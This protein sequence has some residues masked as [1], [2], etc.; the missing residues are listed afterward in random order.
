M[1]VPTIVELINHEREFKVLC[2]GL[3]RFELGPFIQTYAGSGA[4]GG[5]DAD[6]IGTIDGRHGRWVFQ[7][8]FRS[9]QAGV[10]AQRAW[11]LR[12]YEAAKGEFDKAGVQGAVGYVLMTNVP[13]TAGSVAKLRQAWAARFGDA[14]FV[15]WDPSQLDP[16]L[17]G[18]EHL[19]RSWT[20]E[21]EA[22]CRE[23]LAAPLWAWLLEA[24]QR[25]A[26]WHN[27]PLWPLDV[28]HTQEQV[29]DGTFRVGF[30]FRHGYAVEPSTR[31]LDDVARDPQFP[32]ASGTAYPRAL[33]PLRKLR[34]AIDVLNRAVQR[35][36]E[37]VELEIV[38]RLPRM[39]AIEPVEAG[40]EVVTVLAFCVLESRWG[41]STFAARSITESGL[42]MRG[43]SR[44]YD[45]P[46]LA[47][48]AVVVE[49]MAQDGEHGNV[50]N[51]VVRART[52]VAM[53]VEE[54]WRRL[55]YVVELGIDAPAEPDAEE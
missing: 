11:L 51:D 34:Q 37:D 42:F 44:I 20:G 27:W 4:D 35:H 6:Y 36:V 50:P 9:P 3:L 14:P 24:R 33:E 38:E 1:S 7:Y 10:R 8:K 25:T 26:A 13:M 29:P 49:S 15:V 54:W 17:K 21:P 32:F 40:Q 43:T 47:G 41:F 53:L 12:L 39:T 16:M 22:R 30:T 5:I 46:E 18:R 23:V 28:A 52:A 55:W 31:A 45:G 48:A 19:A 2:D